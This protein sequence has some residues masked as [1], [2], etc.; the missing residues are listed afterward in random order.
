LKRLRLLSG[1]RRGDGG[2]LAWT[3]RGRHGPD[4]GSLADPNSDAADPDIGAFGDDYWFVATGQRT[5]KRWH[6]Q[7]RARKKANA[8]FFMALSFFGANSAPLLGRV[9]AWYS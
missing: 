4:A 6:R 2:G 9:L 5:G 7:E 8:T 1:G 3:Y